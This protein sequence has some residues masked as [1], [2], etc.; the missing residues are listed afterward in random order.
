MDALYRKRGLGQWNAR[1]GTLAEFVDALAELPLLF[2][3]GERWNYSVATDVVGRL[4]EVVSGMALDRFL[5]E[6]ILSPL[7]MRDTAFS[8]SN[9]RLS[10][11]ATCY[12]KPFGGGATRRQDGVQDS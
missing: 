10:R 5:E 8:I 6:R 7:G 11:L 9:E 4:V 3:P 12:E 2:S 1:G